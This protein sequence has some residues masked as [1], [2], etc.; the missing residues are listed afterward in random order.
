MCTLQVP[1]K[2]QEQYLGLSELNTYCDVMHDE[3]WSLSDI[4]RAVTIR[5]DD[6]FCRPTL[7]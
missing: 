7:A 3:A 2:A 4:L 5:A 6:T 1:D